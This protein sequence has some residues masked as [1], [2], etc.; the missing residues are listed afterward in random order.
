MLDS[1]PPRIGGRYRPIRLLGRG[2]MGIVYEVEHVHTSEILALKVLS[3]PALANEDTL[4]RF[5][6]EARVPARIRSEHVVRIVDADA[7]PEL[8]GAPYLVMELLQGEDLRRA[9]GDAPQPPD[10]VIDWLAQ[11]ARALDKAHALGIIHRD[12]KPENIFLTRR[13]DAPSVIKVL[14]FGIAK[15]TLDGGPLTA[16]DQFLGTP[17]FMAPEQAGVDGSPI[18]ARTDLFSLGLIAYKLLTGRS[19]W[20]NDSFLPLVREICL[21]PMTPPST[22]GVALGPAFDEWFARACNRNQAMRFDNATSQVTALAAALGLG[23]GERSVTTSAIS[24]PSPA[25]TGNQRPISRPAL[26]T[27]T[28]LVVAAAATMGGLLTAGSRKSSEP[29][30]LTSKTGPAPSGTAMGASDA[31]SS[32]DMPT[33]AAPAPT[34]SETNP[35]RS[36]PVASP[37]SASPR[38]ARGRAAPTR[39]PRDPFAEQH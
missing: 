38:P 33:F 28:V 20:A 15:M 24:V 17:L 22:R 14:D 6:R 21:E 32:E 7:A 30:G 35:A 9:T 19:Y 23:Q 31:G 11:V 2:G 36:L 8:G 10:R 3:H 26:A 5:R 1:L 25:P 4:E 13:D 34:A 37:E 39:P 18:T 16:S 12:L 29:P 27:A